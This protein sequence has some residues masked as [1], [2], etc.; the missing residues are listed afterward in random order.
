MTTTPRKRNR[1]PTTAADVVSMDPPFPL[2][3]DDALCF[4]QLAPPASFGLAPDVLAVRPETGASMS[5]SLMNGLLH[6]FGIEE[7][8]EK[9][10]LCSLFAF[11]FE[12]G[13][14]GMFDGLN[15]LL[16]HMGYAVH[17]RRVSDQTQYALRLEIDRLS[18]GLQQALAETAELRR[19]RG[20]ETAEV[21]RKKSELDELIREQNIS[22][23]FVQEP[24]DEDQ[25]LSGEVIRLTDENAA[26]HEEVNAKQSA[27]TRWC[28]SVHH[29]HAARV[30]T[31]V[32]RSKD[33]ALK[34]R[35]A[36]IRRITQHADDLQAQLFS[37]GKDNQLKV[38]CRPC[39]S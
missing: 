16:A 9:A 4:P 36:I 17:Q 6:D 33:A 27:I 19:V 15:A 20:I 12:Q 30:T 18:A 38:A 28:F 14:G 31:V 11:V 13:I 25:A 2:I 29:W 23:V 26:L 37:T 10:R 39:C 3:N 34:E 22:D 7:P 35:D 21:D 1:Q 8:V 5:F 32:F 24:S